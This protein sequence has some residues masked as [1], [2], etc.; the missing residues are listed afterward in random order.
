MQGAPRACPRPGTSSGTSARAEW[1]GMHRKKKRWFPGPDATVAAGDGLAWWLSSCTSLVA[2]SVLE[3]AEHTP[4]T[5]QVGLPCL[6][7][8]CVPP[9][10][11]AITAAKWYPARE[12]LSGRKD[13]HRIRTALCKMHRALHKG[14]TCVMRETLTTM[15]DYRT[16]RE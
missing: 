2:A 13:T 12:G 3:K 10:P 7:S 15:V 11:A 9:G 16:S 6:H 14:R 1:A 5:V 4:H 8:A